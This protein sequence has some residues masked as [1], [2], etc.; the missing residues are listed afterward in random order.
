MN[1]T[2]MLVMLLSLAAAFAW[3]AS[4]RW[5]LLRVGRPLNRF[6]DIATRAKGTWIY[7]FAQKKMRYYW[8]AGF[9]HK[10]IFVGFL[11]L[12][13]VLGIVAALT[14][15]EGRAAE[16]LTGFFSSAATALAIAYF[17]AITVAVYRQLAG[18]LEADAGAPFD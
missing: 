5:Q 18:R 10:L 6:D 16:I 13:I 11:V 1:P 17:A 4:R 2:W 9:A 3:S 7:A 12:T 8:L 14:M 15:G